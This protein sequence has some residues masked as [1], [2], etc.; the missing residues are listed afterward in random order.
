MGAIENLKQIGRL[1]RFADLASK[2]LLHR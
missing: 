2:L 1:Q